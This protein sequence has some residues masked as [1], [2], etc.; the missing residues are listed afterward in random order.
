MGVSWGLPAEQGLEGL[1]QGLGFLEQGPEFPQGVST[2]EVS[3][4]RVSSWIQAVMV[5]RK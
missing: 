3:L 1:E 5:A 2:T 4:W